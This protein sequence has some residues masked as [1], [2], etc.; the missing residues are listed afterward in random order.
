MRWN[1]SFCIKVFW[2]QYIFRFPL[3]LIVN[4][5]WRICFCFLNEFFL[6]LNWIYFKSFLFWER[7]SS[8]LS[9]EHLWTIFL[10]ICRLINLTS[11][12]NFDIKYILREIM[13]Q[14]CPIVTSDYFKC[15]QLKVITSM[16][17]AVLPKKWGTIKNRKMVFQLPWVFCIF[18]K[19]SQEIH[20]CYI[21]IESII[22]KR[23]PFSL[24]QR[25]ITPQTKFKQKLRLIEKFLWRITLQMF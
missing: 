15:I 10:Q 13:Y 16:H 23:L 1:F 5:F 21:R 14:H 2:I 4:T 20:T 19:S 6:I 12:I 9:F 8:F 11:I 25:N 7:K 24:S 22:M 18:P 17:F 3:F